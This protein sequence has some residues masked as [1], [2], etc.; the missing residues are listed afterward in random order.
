MRSSISGK[1]PTSYVKQHGPR[2]SGTSGVI[3]CPC[4]YIKG[5]VYFI[6]FRRSQS[7]RR[8][9]VRHD[10]KK[11]VK[12]RYC[13]QQSL[14]HVKFTWIKYSFFE[15]TRGNIS[16]LET[17]ICA[18]FEEQTHT[19]TCKTRELFLSNPLFSC[20][21]MGESYLKY[22]KGSALLFAVDH[23]IILTNCRACWTSGCPWRH[24]LS[25]V[26]ARQKNFFPSPEICSLGEWS[27]L[28]ESF[29]KHHIFRSRSS[30]L[31]NLPEYLQSW[32]RTPRKAK[33]SRKFR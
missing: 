7:E 20:P 27:V 3:S 18:V 29:I 30:R 22:N 16:V 32:E 1:T 6:Y 24:M 25:K 23:A 15:S 19:I 33:K 14:Y 13:F 26:S 12:G 28:R 17:R 9:V 31:K 10:R 5:I 4:R 21:L 2:N 11:P 8:V